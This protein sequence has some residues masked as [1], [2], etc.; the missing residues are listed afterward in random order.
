ME[1]N[2]ISVFKLGTCQL[3]RD[4]ETPHNVPLSSGVKWSQLRHRDS[5]T[6][7]SKYIQVCSSLTA[8]ASLGAPR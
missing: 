6:Q 1:K 8:A 3:L 5:E 4:S 2:F 7:A